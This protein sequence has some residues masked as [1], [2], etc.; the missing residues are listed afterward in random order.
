MATRLLAALGAEVVKIEGPERYDG[1]RND[2]AAPTHLESY[3]GRLPGERPYNRNAWFNTQNPGKASVAIDLKAPEGLDLARRLV[4][5]SDV[6]IGNFSAGTMERLGLGYDALRALAPD[7][8]VVEMSGFGDTGPLAQ[9]RALGQTMEAL[10][11]ITSLIGYPDGEPLGSGSA[12][13]DPVGGFVGAAAVLTALVSRQRFGGG[14]RIEVPQREAAMHLIGELLIEAIRDDRS[15]SPSGNRSPRAAPHD[16]FR[17]RGDDRWLALAAFDDAQ[18][19]ALCGTLE[20]D[21]LADDPRFA[22]T[23]TRAQNA[24]ALSALIADRVAGLDSDS[25]ARRLQAA[26]VPA[27]PVQNGRDLVEDAQLRSRGWF[28]RLPHADAGT[29][30]YPGVPIEIDGSLAAPDAAS[31]RLGEHTRAVLEGVVGVPR[32]EVDRLAAAGVVLVADGC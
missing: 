27:A 16:A 9:L 24:D 21:A 1:W 13:L 2:R 4:A 28:T 30:D 10:S 3:P 31:P 26:G 7:I 11:G 29:H 15:P 23:R 14:Q 32:S 8:V 22:T 6:V 12:Y 17:C 19:R 5:R 25:T 18:W 20:L